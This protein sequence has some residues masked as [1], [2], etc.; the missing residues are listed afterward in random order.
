MTETTYFQE[1]R[2]EVSEG[3]REDGSD[4]TVCVVDEHGAEQYLH[5]TRGL[6]NVEGRTSYLPVGFVRIDREGRRVLV[7]LPCEADSGA[8]RMWV[9]FEMLRHRER[10]VL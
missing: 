7:E 8:N 5:V 10:A 3:I 9:K 4:I 2:C 1:V 6:I